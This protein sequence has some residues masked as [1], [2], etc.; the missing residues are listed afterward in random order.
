MITGIFS[1]TS[2]NG[3]NWIAICVDQNCVN[4]TWIVGIPANYSDPNPYTTLIGTPGII[5]EI[6]NVQVYDFAFSKNQL[7]T[8]FD[9]GYAGLPVSTNGLIAWLPL[10]GNANDYSGNNNNGIATNINWVSP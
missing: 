7:A 9:L 4:H 6:S 2:T 5:A 1:N 8:A 3:N 10:D